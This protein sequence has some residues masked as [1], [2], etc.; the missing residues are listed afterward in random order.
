VVTTVVD[1]PNVSMSPQRYR[2]IYEMARQVMR[3]V[4]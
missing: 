3:A 1:V 2:A 4:G